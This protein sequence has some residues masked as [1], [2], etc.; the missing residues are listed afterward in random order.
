MDQKG[1]TRLELIDYNSQKIC[2]QIKCRPSIRINHKII[3]MILLFKFQ[4]ARR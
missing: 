3:V 1:L 4:F 2:K